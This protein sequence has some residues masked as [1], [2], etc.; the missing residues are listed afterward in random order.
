MFYIVVT[1]PDRAREGRIAMK[2]LAKAALC[3]AY[4]L[5]G[6]ARL[7]EGRARRAGRSF[8]VILLFHRVTDAI[9]EDGLTVSTTRFRRIC[10][11]LRRGFHVVPLAEVFRLARSGAPLPPRAAA[12]TF[13]DCYHDNLAAAHVL[14]EHGLPA[15]FFVPAAWVGTRQTFPWDRHLVPLANLSWED[16]R[17]MARLGF[18]IGSHTLTHPNLAAL[19]LEEARREMVE[20]KRLIEE[21]VGRPVRWL[22]YP[23]GER[24]H[25]RDEL[26]PVVAEAG[27]AGCLSGHGGFIQPGMDGLLLPR[28][29]V[30]YFRSLLNLEL[31]LR[32]CLDWFYDLKRRSPTRAAGLVPAG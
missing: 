24:E 17:A 11:M 21:Q 16:V 7:Q 13:D 20:S 26:L 2:T 14:A 28:E 18:E 6:A 32:G 31:H 22:A 23:F 30:S 19:A 5:S 10:R 27:Y 1:A 8:A 29:P 25:F 3:A 15:T 9:P 4:K 12:V